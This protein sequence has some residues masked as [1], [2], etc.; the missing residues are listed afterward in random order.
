M[1][2][3]YKLNRFD[4][5]VNNY[6][7][8]INS[9]VD[10][11]VSNRLIPFKYLLGLPLMKDWINKN[12]IDILEYGVTYL[13]VNKESILNFDIKNLDELD[14]L[15]SDSDDNVS[16]KECITKISKLKSDTSIDKKIGLESGF[17]SNEILNIIIEIK[18]NSK[19]LDEFSVNMIK[20]YV[21][22]LILIL[23]QIKMLF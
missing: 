20:Q 18:N 7:D 5:L 14:E 16:R 17:E 12:R 9:L 13:L 6:I 19:K 15:D 11:A 21:E 4:I 1:D 2:L 10:L 23:E 8:T 3:D 22:L